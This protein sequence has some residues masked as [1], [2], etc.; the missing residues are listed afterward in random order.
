LAEETAMLPLWPGATVALLGGGSSLTLQQIEHVRGRCR[1]I[2]INRAYRLMPEAD[3]LHAADK[4]WWEE[5]PD[6]LV[7]QGIKTTCQAGVDR[8]VIFIRPSGIW[9]FE[10]DPSRVRTG[11]C[12]G[13]QAIQFA[14]RSGA[15]RVLLLGYDGHRGNWHE[16]YNRPTVPYEGHCVVEYRKLAPYLAAKGV[17]MLNCS[18]RSIYDAFPIVNLSDVLK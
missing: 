4:W 6:A 9:G 17:E 10:H 16:G 3:W 7:F 12:S 8:R 5:H 15:T 13:Y 2:A 11:L 1:V 18:P 14:V